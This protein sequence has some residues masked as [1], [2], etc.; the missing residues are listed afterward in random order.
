LCIHQSDRLLE[1]I[2]GVRMAIITRAAAEVRQSSLRL[3]TTCLRVRDLA[4]KGF[5]QIEKLDPSGNGKGFQ[6]LLNAGR[7]KKLADYLLDAYSEGDAFLPT[8]VFL[9]TNK[10]IVLNAESNTIT[11]DTDQVGPFNVVDGQHRIAG[12]IAAAE[13]NPDLLDFEIPV[14]I[15]VELNDISQMCHFLIV[16]TTQHSVDEGVEQQIVARLTSM[17]EIEEM[18]TIPNWIRRQVEKG[19]DSRALSIVDFLNNDKDSPW[20]Q[21]IRM[22]TEEKDSDQTIN[23]KSFVKSLK[24]YVLNPS[25][26]L[27]EASYEK[28]R[29]KMLANYWKAI[30]Q[31]LVDENS[32]KS[33]VIYKTTGVEL[34]CPRKTLPVEAGVLS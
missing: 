11:F 22:A 28:N 32:L 12:L 9:A 4:I 8:S 6:R 27:A 7:A 18:P 3:F 34:T 29:P 26:P 15:A 21:K 14:N 20:Y 30:I 1:T 5:Y 17:L 16:N 23:Q 25:N 10:N 31:L 33:S 19:E 13:K 24:R 2:L